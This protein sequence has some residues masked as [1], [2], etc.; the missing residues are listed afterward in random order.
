MECNAA[1]AFYLLQ[2]VVPTFMSFFPPFS[3]LI[4]KTLLN[5]VV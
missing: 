3:V 5:V 2:F 4:S 1:N